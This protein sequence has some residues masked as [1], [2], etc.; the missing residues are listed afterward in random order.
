[1]TWVNSS[2]RHSACN[3]APLDGMCCHLGRKCALRNIEPRQT[4]T[5]GKPETNSALSICEWVCVEKFRLWENGWLNVI[6]VFEACIFLSLRRLS[7]PAAY[8]FNGGS[9]IPSPRNEVETHEC[10]TKTVQNLLWEFDWK[11]LWFVQLCCKYTHASLLA[12]ASLLGMPMCGLSPHPTTWLQC[13]D[14]HLT[15]PPGLK[16][17][18]SP[19]RPFDQSKWQ[20]G[21]CSLHLLHEKFINRASGMRLHAHLGHNAFFS[22]MLVQFLLNISGKRGKPLLF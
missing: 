2:F 8:H 9:C 6:W 10:T 13:V 1:M 22:V 18:P 4:V 19:P 20:Y 7:R 11:N 14:C 12:R 17:S 21:W 5:V 15:P 3:L 16:N